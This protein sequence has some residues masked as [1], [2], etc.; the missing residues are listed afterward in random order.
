MDFVQPD[1]VVSMFQPVLLVCPYLNPED[2]MSDLVRCTNFRSQL[3]IS[4]R[5]C[6]Q[7]VERCE[8]WILQTICFA[9]WSNS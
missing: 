8:I 4:I 9:I 6:S 3:N 2:L 7:R 1:Y 5:T